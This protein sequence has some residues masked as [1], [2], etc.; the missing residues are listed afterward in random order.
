M[1]KLLTV[2]TGIL[3]RRAFDTAAPALLPAGKQNATF[4]HRPFGDAP[5]LNSGDAGRN[6]CLVMAGTTSNSTSMPRL[7]KQQDLPKPRKAGS[8]DQR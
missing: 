8:S 3:N 4:R 7:R 1:G 5:I 2:S 6:L